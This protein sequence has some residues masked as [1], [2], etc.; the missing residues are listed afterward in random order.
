MRGGQ[1]SLVIPAPEAHFLVIAAPRPSFARSG[2]HPDGTHRGALFCLAAIRPFSVRPLT[3]LS[4]F[5]SCG[6]LRMHLAALASTRLSLIKEIVKRLICLQRRR[7]DRLFELDRS[8]NRPSRKLFAAGSTLPIVTKT[9]LRS[10]RSIALM[11]RQFDPFQVPHAPKCEA[12][13]TCPHR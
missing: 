9:K 1:S 8:F 10:H 13:H 5:L 2:L 3:R 11:G 7:R 12:E 4:C 6:W